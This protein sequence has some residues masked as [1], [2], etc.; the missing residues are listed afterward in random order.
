ME[1]AHQGSAA[2]KKLA[3]RGPQSLDTF[4]VGLVDAA[5]IVVLDVA[6][7]VVAHSVKF[8]D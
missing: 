4:A 2:I 6:T 3:N 5:G 1:G 8:G 7:I